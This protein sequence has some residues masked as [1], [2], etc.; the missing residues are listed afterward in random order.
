AVLTNSTATGCPAVALAFL[1][2]DG[3]QDTTIDT[4]TDT[5]VLDAITLDQTGTWTVLVDPQGAATG[6]ATL[7]AYQKTDNVHAVNVNGAPVNV[8]L[9][10]PGQN[11]SYT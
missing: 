9:S 7:Q 1:R 4:C 5:V 8:L 10:A 2:P 11:G 3:T 6:T